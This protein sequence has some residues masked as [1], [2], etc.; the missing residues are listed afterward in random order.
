[1]LYKWF[2]R[3]KTFS[4]VDLLDKYVSAYKD[5]LNSGTGM[6]SY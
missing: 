5:A 6:V 4:Y 1:M 2:R 3:N